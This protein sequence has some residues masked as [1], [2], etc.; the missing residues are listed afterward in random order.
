MHLNYK[1][2]KLALMGLAALCMGVLVFAISLSPL[3]GR[4]GG[5]AALITTMFGT[6]GAQMFIGSLGALVMLGA[7]R[8]IWLS[9]GEAFAVKTGPRGIHVRSAY[10]SG[11]LPWAS[12]ASVQGRIVSG[13]GKQPV[14]VIY[15]S[16]KPGLLLRLVGLG[17]KL[18][19]QPKL[20]DANDHA[21]NAWIE[22]ARNH[23]APVRTEWTGRPLAQPNR[24]FGRRQ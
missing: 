5:V 24:V 4:G 2:S 11:F 19:I 16:D 10:Y 18:V 9:I 20:L 13:W 15:R 12:I 7:L 21:V 8:L 22:T 17:D 6:T 3:E 1:R 23:G 14:L